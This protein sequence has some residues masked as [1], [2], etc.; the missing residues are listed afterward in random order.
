MDWF[1]TTM[2]GTVL[3]LS[4]VAGCTEGSPAL[5]PP[6]FSSTTSTVLQVDQ[7]PLGGGNIDQQPTLG[8]GPASPLV[9]D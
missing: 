8:G 5:S 9:Y 2:I 3:A 7:N 1:K 6:S 4:L